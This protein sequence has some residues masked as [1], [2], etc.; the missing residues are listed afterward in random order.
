MGYKNWLL[1]VF[2]GLGESIGFV[3]LIG[4]V[5]FVGLENVGGG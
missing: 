3:E 5:E 4:L 1:R 2:L